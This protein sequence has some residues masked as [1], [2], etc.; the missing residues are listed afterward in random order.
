[1]E[2]GGSRGESD[3]DVSRKNVARDARLQALKMEGGDSSQGLWSASRSWKMQGN[4]FSPRDYRMECN[5]VD[6]F[7][8]AQ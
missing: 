7:I 3:S 6:T 2:E 8:L 1:M 5:Y 4:R